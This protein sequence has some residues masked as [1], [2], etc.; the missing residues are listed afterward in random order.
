MLNIEILSLRS[1][2]TDFA[3]AL[4]SSNAWFR[5]GS[6]V[7]VLKALKTPPPDVFDI[8]FA[9][10]ASPVRERRATARL[11]WLGDA[12]ILAIPAPVVGP[13]PIRIAIPEG[14]ILGE[15]KCLKESIVGSL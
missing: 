12:R 11:P 1:S 15:A 10:S 6:V 7:S 3:Q 14:G 13:A 2:P 8:V 5:D 4:I 9:S